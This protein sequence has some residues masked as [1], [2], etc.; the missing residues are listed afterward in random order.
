M[1]TFSAEDPSSG[2]VIVLF[3]LGPLFGLFFSFR[4]TPEGNCNSLSLY[5]LP[6]VYL[7]ISSSMLVAR[8]TNETEE[9]LWY[10]ASM[11][12]NSLQ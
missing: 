9:W 8:L 5:D 12:L 4:L 11:F 1:L 6:G 3:F 2:F 10:D 7:P